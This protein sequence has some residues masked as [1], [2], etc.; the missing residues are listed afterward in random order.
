MIEHIAREAGKDQ[1]ELMNATSAFWYFSYRDASQSVES[2]LGSILKQLTKTSSRVSP[3]L[4]EAYSISKDKDTAP[5]LEI[6]LEALSDICEETKDVLV[7]IDALDECAEELRWPLIDA[8]RDCPSNLRLMI[9]SRYLDN[10]ED[11]L[12]DFAKIEIK[13]HKDDLELFVDRHIARSRNLKRIVEKSTAMRGDIKT[14]V[15]RTSE[16]MYGINKRFLAGRTDTS[17]VSASAPP[18]RVSR[19]LSRSIY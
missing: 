9:T 19:Q 7:V 11:E 15:I 17:Q 10:I 8:L 13:A 14:A 2:V 18:C 3:A 1:S 4:A 6:L 16:D 5:T 12:E